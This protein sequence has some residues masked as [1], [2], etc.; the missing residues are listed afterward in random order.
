ML[1]A[2]QRKHFMKGG[3]ENVQL[4]VPLKTKA[5]ERRIMHDFG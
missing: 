1:P 2:V 4:S 3:K 5:L